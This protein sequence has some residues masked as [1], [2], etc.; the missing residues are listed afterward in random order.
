MRIENWQNNTALEEL[1]VGDCF[2][3]HSAPYVKIETE[4][5][6]LGGYTNP[7]DKMCALNLLT[8]TIQIL[9]KTER[10]ERFSARVV[11]D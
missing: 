2:K 10:V 8:N 9:Y 7:D 3:W 11:I 4:Y 6:D 5:V 1:K